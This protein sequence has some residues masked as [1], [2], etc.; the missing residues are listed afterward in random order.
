MLQIHSCFTFAADEDFLKNDIRVKPDL[1]GLGALGD[2]GWYGLR[3]ILWAA[4]Y[5][6]PKTVVAL[7]GPILNDA[8]VI[9]A[10]GASFHW[11][12]GKVATFHCSFLTHLT[13]YI[14]AIGTKGTLH[15]DDF[16]IPFNEK[17]FSYTASSKC[18]FNEPV[19]GW[20]PL[21][22]QHTVFTDLP[23][24]ACMVREFARLVANVKANG[25]KPDQSWPSRSRKT[26][27]LLDAVK[28]SIE[29][30][31]EPVEVTN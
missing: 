14:T 16:I 5:E 30:G 21:P 1:D 4:D 27:L 13:M 17:E 9:L 8:G 26:Q 29:K 10:C 25:A 3:A 28:T 11:E 7:R 19:T 12:D 20:D 6:L 15:L 23:Q 2:A 22:S 24:E 18:W 31:F